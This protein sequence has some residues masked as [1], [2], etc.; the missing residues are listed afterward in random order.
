M[1]LFMQ[2]IILLIINTI[3]EGHRA[4]INPWCY[5][6]SRKFFFFLKKLS[7]F[8]NQKIKKYVNRTERWEHSDTGYVIYSQASTIGT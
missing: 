3:V 8:W 6:T 7:N 4:M 2:L 1:I 5:S